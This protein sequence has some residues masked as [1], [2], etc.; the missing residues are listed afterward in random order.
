M[1]RRNSSLGDFKK[2]STHKHNKTLD[3]AIFCNCHS[4]LTP[5]WIMKICRI[6]ERR[7]GGGGGGGGEKEGERVV[8]MCCVSCHFTTT[9]FMNI[10]NNILCSAG[11]AMA[12]ALQS[13]NASPSHYRSLLQA[14]RSLLVDLISMYS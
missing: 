4:Y 11:D 1:I 9:I 2:T 6:G 5:A 10:N 7:G 12:R 3:S 13:S 14:L 8:K